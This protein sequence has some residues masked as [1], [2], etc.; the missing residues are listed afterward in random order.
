MT[1]PQPEDTTV[2]IGLIYPTGSDGVISS[3]ELWTLWFTCYAW[4]DEDGLL[5]KNKLELRA[6]ATRDDLRSQ[7]NHLKPYPIIRA[8]V[9]LKDKT[10][11]HLL[12]LIDGHVDD[13]ELGQIAVELQKPLIYEH[14]RFG[15]FVFDWHSNR[16]EAAVNWAGQSVKLVI[17]GDEISDPEDDFLQTAITLW[18]NQPVWNQR[19]LDY[20]IEDLLELKNDVWLDE[21]E[22]PLSATEFISSMTLKSIIVGEEGEFDFWYNDGDLFLGHFIEVRGDLENGPTHADIPG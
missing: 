12:E 7:M 18:D 19:I 5:H 4:R 10:S 16:W 8:R 6:A 17:Y 9:I 3:W 15:T 20:A 13:Q 1:H 21:D 11:A 14:E 2:I 22:M